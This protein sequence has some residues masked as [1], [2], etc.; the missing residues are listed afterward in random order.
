MPLSYLIQNDGGRNA[1]AKLIIIDADND[2]FSNERM[3]ENMAFHVERRDLVSARF[4]NCL[5]A[6][7][8]AKRASARTV[9]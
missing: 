5:L 9:N 3:F 1:L 2:R 4:K 6:E 7:L 8:G